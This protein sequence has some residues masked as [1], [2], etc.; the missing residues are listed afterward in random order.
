MSL[1]TLKNYYL[2]ILCLSLL[3][4]QTEID[5]L[6]TFTNCGQTGYTGPSQGQCDSEYGA[7]EVIVNN[8]IQ[9]WTVTFTG[10][11]YIEALGAG[12]G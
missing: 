12:G 7:G 8:G 2:P 11:Y 3:F 5:T 4:S 6:W 10:L 9:E 1:R